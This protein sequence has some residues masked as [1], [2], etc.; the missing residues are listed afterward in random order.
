MTVKY[1]S[2]LD[3]HFALYVLS[4]TPDAERVA[5]EGMHQ[6]YSEKAV[7]EE[8]W[9]E[10]INYGAAVVK[11]L[12]AGDRGHYSPL[13]HNAITFNV[14]G[15]PHVVM[16]QYRTH[17]T[18]ISFS[19]QSTRYTG[20]RIIESINGHRS[21]DEVFYVR[22]A[23]EYAGRAG[24]YDITE[25]EVNDMV[26]LMSEAAMLY[27]RLVTTFGYDS[28]AARYVIPYSIRQNFVMTVNARSLM[29]LLDLRHKP[30][31]EL[32]S[33]EL[34]HMMLNAFR[35]WMPNVCQWYEEKRLNKGRLAP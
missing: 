18:G 21:F 12:L 1:I 13:E 33:R 34:A 20:A 25:D 32:E 9:R 11:H 35:D 4:C 15:F 19:V 30:D 6:C 14:V 27:D 10:D 22:K 8:N 28:E 26:G 17:R 2:K 3:N 5:W 16:Q 23:G 7:A 31:A 29:H 24:K